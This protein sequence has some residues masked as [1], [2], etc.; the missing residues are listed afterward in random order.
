[1]RIDIDGIKCFQE[2]CQIYVDGC[3]ETKKVMLSFLNDSQKSV[4]LSLLGLYNIFT[5]E[6]YRKTICTIKDGFIRGGIEK[7]SDI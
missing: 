6:Q 3:T 7:I 1:M 4:F 2:M 5:D